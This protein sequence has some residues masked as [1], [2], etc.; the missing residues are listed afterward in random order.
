MLPFRIQPKE[1]IMKKTLIALATVATITLAASAAMAEFGPGEGM[2]RGGPNI[3]RMARMLDLTPAQQEQV[4]ALFA[5][6]MKEHEAMRA[7][8]QQKM[9][10]ILTKDQ[11]AK[12]DDMRKFHE[13][14]HE[15]GMHGGNENC[16]GMGEG[17]HGPDR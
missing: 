15:H 8:M 6:Q 2:M 12:M 3:E 5:E 16:R 17:M 14:H 4:K 7:Q 13:E 11:I 1:D 9:Q 10:S